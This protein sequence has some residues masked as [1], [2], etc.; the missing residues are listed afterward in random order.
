MDHAILGTSGV[1]IDFGT[2][3]PQA[4]KAEVQASK[5][6][7]RLNNVLVDAWLI[8][9][10]LHGN[11][12]VLKIWLQKYRDRLL[13]L[14]K[15]DPVCQALEEPIRVIRE[16]LEFKPRLAEKVAKMALGPQLVG[17]IDSD[18]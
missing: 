8:G 1:E 7:Q 16:K 5:A 9:Q 6:R 13:E 14:A 3:R 18:T 17:I 11:S 10:E 15:D 2:G 4:P 12:Q